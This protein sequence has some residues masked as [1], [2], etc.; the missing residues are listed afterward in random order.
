V[1]LLVELQ[2]PPPFAIRGTKPVGVAPLARVVMNKATAGGAHTQRPARMN[3]SQ[4]VTP[5]QARRIGV[6]DGA[7]GLMPSIRRTAWP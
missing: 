1:R 5:A 4:Q 6:V 3:R 7:P 2:S